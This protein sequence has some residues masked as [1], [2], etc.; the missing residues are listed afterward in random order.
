ML[1][2]GSPNWFFQ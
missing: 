2:N 1:V